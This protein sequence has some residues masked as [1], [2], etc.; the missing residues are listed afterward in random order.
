MHARV[1]GNA[2]WPVDRQIVANTCVGRTSRL[3]VFQLT[4][5]QDLAWM[6]SAEPCGIDGQQNHL[7]IGTFSNDRRSDTGIPEHQDDALPRMSS[8]ILIV[9]LCDW[10]VAL[11]APVAEPAGEICSTRKPVGP[12]Q[13]ECGQRGFVHRNKRLV[14]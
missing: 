7:G 12:G 9:L 2:F 14:V 1:S 8:H 11:Q 10:F 6:G 13:R 4:V 3:R 5:F